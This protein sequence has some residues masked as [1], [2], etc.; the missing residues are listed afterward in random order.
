MDSVN[1]W[2]CVFKNVI[3][4]LFL[5]SSFAFLSKISI[6]TVQINFTFSSLVG[7]K[8]MRSYLSKILQIIPS[9]LCFFLDDNLTLFFPNFFFDSPWF[10]LRKCAYQELKNVRFSDVFKEIKRVKARSI[11]ILRS[12]QIVMDA[13]RFIYSQT[14]WKLSKYGIFSGPHF[15]VF[16]PEKTRYLD[17]FHAVL[18]VVNYFCKKFHYHRYMMNPKFAYCHRTKNKTCSKTVIKTPE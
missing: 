18:I 17:N 6:K 14:A 13:W 10:H 4:T 16:E 11:R 5:F 7:I 15:P 1:L 9:L 8:S 3:I 12:C 2:F